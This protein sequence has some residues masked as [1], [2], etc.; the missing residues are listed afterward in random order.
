MNKGNPGTIILRWPSGAAELNLGTCFPATRSEMAHI[1]KLLRL[2]P[3]AAPDATRRCLECINGMLPRL[4]D[5][6]RDT[7]RRYMERRQ[8][9]AD[10]T[11]RATSGRRRRTPRETPAA[12][13]TATRRRSGAPSETS[14][15]CGR[16]RPPSNTGHSREEIKP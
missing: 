2:D 6:E 7:Y 16:T 11:E 3:E 4:Q 14:S 5:H 13:R 12:K 15:G 1:Q 9:A 10:A 8:I